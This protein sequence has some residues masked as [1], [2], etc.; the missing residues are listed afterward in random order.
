MA[1]ISAVSGAAAGAAAAAAGYFLFA[2]PLIALVVLYPVVGELV[3]R[4][5]QWA[6]DRNTAASPDHAPRLPCPY[7]G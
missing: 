5:V 6:L 1:L 7:F 3:S 2:A 4:A